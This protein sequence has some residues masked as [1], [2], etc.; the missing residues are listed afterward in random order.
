MSRYIIKNKIT[1]PKNLKKFNL[2]DYRFNK[3]LSSDSDLV[4]TR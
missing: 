2:E 4:F 1:N 3:V